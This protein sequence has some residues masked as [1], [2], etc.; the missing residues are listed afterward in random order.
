MQAQGH[1]PAHLP[2]DWSHRHVVFSPPNSMMQARK[3]QEEPRYWHQQFRRYLRTLPA[4]D[5]EPKRSE[6]ADDEDKDDHDGHHRSRASKNQL[7]GD[8]GMSLGAGASGGDEMYPA[9][10]TFDVNAVPSC[11]NDFV[12]FNTG[13]AGGSATDAGQ[14]GTFTNQP[15][16]GNT[17]T[18]GGTEVLTVTAATTSATGTATINSGPNA[19]DTITI[20]S[21][22]YTFGFNA[23]GT[24]T[25]VSLPNA[26]DT[27]I[28]GSTT[29]KFVTTLVSANDV[30]IAGTINNTARNLR[31][32]I[33]GNSNECPGGGGCFGTGTAANASA[34]ASS[35]NNVVTVTA[36]GAA[37]N[38]VALGTTGGPRITVSGATLSGG[39][40]N[41]SSANEVAA[42]AGSTTN[43][44]TNLAAAILGQSGQCFSN[45]PC[46]GTGTT[47]NASVTA[48]SNN[49]VVTVTA[50]STGVGGNSIVFTT[51][52]GARITLSP[53]TGTLSGGANG[54]SNT[55][56]SFQIGANTAAT[57]TNL[58]AAIARNGGGVGVTAT[59]SQQIVVVTATT[60]GTAGNSITLS[61]TI[62][63]SNF[64]WG[65]STLDGGAAAPGTIIAF[66]NLYSTQNGATPAGLCGSAGPSLL[67]SYNTDIGTNGT[68]TTTGAALTSPVLSLDG[69]KIAYVE[70]GATNH[71]I[72]RLLKW[73]KDTVQNPPAAP[74]QVIAAGSAWT[75]CTG[76]APHSCLIGLPFG[77]NAQDTESAPFYLYG[78][79]T[80]YVGDDAGK[81]HK[82]IN[83]FGLSGSTPSEVT[84]GG[85][86]VTVNGS[87]TVHLHSPIYDS[88]SGNIF[89]GDLAGNIY[90]V[91]EAG[92]S[93]GVC[94]SGSNGGVAPCLGTTNGLASGPTSIAL[95]GAIDDAPIVDSTTERV[96]FFNGAVNSATCA[97]AGTNAALVQLNTQ[98]ATASEVT[99]CF[100]NNGTTNQLTNTKSGAFDNTYQSSAMGSKTG[101]LYVCARQSGSRDHPAL[102]RIGFNS[103]GVMNST[104]DANSGGSGNNYLDLVGGSGEECSPITEIY[105]TNTSTDWLFLSV[106][107]NAGLGS[108]NNSNG[109]LMSFNL[110]T[111]GT[112]WPPADATASYDLPP[113][114]TNPGDGGSSGIIVD[115]VVNTTTYPQ[116]SSIYFT[117]LTTATANATCNGDVSTGCAVKL[118]QA[119]LQ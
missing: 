84:T 99:V 59:S 32:A 52:A 65:G 7:H 61:T 24:V 110:T 30:L 88:A 2:T 97:A 82:F 20:G 57:A 58:A 91:R 69:S 81:L 4:A 66:N 12:A 111:L 5:S 105:N 72:L 56:T 78:S 67:F 100:P 1:S 9:K 39:N 44:A 102:F 13:V 118:T 109:C 103:S 90:Y 19:G 43:T 80:L 35:N 22:T 70:S 11:A 75:G 115:N 117:F 116:A 119:A 74:D 95:G 89:V 6:D 94:G 49:N 51:T 42:V 46:F 10:F 50:S 8:W 3:L 55:G 15:A 64:T 107:N 87:G 37:G 38:T 85:W 104:V 62:N 73:A 16:V 41:F 114:G 25:V 98:L 48:N 79:D 71:A 101:K 96:F 86:P 29:Y 27:V 34:T 14:T 63:S 47:A 60:A 28:V 68:G 54:G 92:S 18:I 33:D 21:T 77:N 93:V 40:G 112:T 106:G 36:P 31:A 113:S 108:C 23:T 76:A 26:N 83:V 17:V 53:N 45:A